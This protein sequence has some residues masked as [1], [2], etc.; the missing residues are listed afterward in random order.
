MLP[1]NATQHSQSLFTYAVTLIQSCPTVLYD[2]AGVSGS[3]ARGVADQFSDCEIPFW[4]DKLQD[5]DTYKTW[6]ESSGRNVKI[7]RESAEP[8]KALYLEYLIDGVK[9]CTIWQTWERLEEVFAALKDNQLPHD[10][11]TPWMLSHL[12]PIGTAPR[13]QKYL[14]QIQ[15][16]P[17]NLRHN[18]IEKQL[19]FWRWKLGVA[20]VFLAEASAHRRH[21]YDL[22]SRQLVNI[23]SILNTLFAY[24]RLWLPEAKWYNEGIEKMT[25]KPHRLIQRIDLLLIQDNPK[26]L[27]PTMC[28]L[29]LDTIHIIADEFTVDDIIT[30]LENFTWIDA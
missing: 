23:N 18:I 5:A 25:H 8:D 24:N 16:Y 15:N 30:G 21:L 14:T 17:D 1:A 2:E 12:I 10:P 28:S 29:M 26:I 27:L 4:L 13:L 22:R 3:V 9:V 11:T 20:D 6:L 7:M 19:A